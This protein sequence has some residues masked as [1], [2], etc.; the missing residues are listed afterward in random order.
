MSRFSRL[1]ATPQNRAPAP[2]SSHRGVSKTP[3][4]QQQQQQQQQRVRPVQQTQAQAP[5][6]GLSRQEAKTPHYEFRVE[7]GATPFAHDDEGEDDERFLALSQ[8]LKVTTEQLHA[9]HMKIK[10]QK[11]ALKVMESTL[12]QEQQM[13]RQLQQQTRSSIGSPGPAL[14]LPLALADLN[15]GTS[16][17]DHR[18]VGWLVR[19]GVMSSAAAAAEEE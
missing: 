19:T 2:Q 3:Q 5:V 4:Q 14:R 17:F 7:A 9:A 10:R 13:H 15:L 6:Q 16:A 1:L 11:H 18:V 12:Q 8:S